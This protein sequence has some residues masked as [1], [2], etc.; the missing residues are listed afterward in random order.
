MLQCHVK[1]K[2][3]SKDINKDD[4]EDDDEH[5]VTQN[6]SNRNLSQSMRDL[7]EYASIQ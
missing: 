4:D 1:F 2:E 5:K 6:L 7:H 3:N